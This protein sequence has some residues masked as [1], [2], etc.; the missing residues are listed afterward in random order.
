MEPFTVQAGPCRLSNVIENT[1]DTF[2]NIVNVGE[3]SAMFAV[4]IHIDGFVLKNILGK[5]E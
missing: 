4:V 5:T 3:I 2:D 1:N